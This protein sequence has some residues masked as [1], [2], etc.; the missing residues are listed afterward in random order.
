[1]ASLPVTNLSLE[2][3]LTVEVI[4]AYVIWGQEPAEELSAIRMSHRYMSRVPIPAS[5]VITEG[6]NNAP[7]SRSVLMTK[8]A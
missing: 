4:F 2:A 7:F 3:V 1:M 5:V 8:A 6:V